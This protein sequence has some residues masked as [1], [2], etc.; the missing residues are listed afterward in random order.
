MDGC[1]V[2][3]SHYLLNLLESILL[4]DH[5][6]AGEDDKACDLEKQ[7]PEGDIMGRMG[8]NSQKTGLRFWFSSVDSC[9]RSLE[10]FKKWGEHLLGKILKKALR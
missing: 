2:C 9:F 7:K 4:K 8:R 3:S 1:P 5:T 10:V 6:Q